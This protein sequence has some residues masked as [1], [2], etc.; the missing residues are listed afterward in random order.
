[1]STKSFSKTAFNAVAALAVGAVVFG[2]GVLK[3]T[4]IEAGHTKN[5]Q[6]R[7][8]Q[9]LAKA[10]KCDTP[11]PEPACTMIEYR[12]DLLLDPTL[13]GTPG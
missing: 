11:S 3:G 9:E 4:I 1:M 6:L 10:N 5:V 8:L 7:L 2:A 13:S 12:R